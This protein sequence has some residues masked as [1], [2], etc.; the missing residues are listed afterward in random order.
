[1]AGKTAKTISKMATV[2]FLLVGAPIFAIVAALA[3][4][5]YF[6]RARSRTSRVILVLCL[7]IVT[8]LFAYVAITIN[9]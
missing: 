7:A 8:V 6:S 4:L 2:T 3:H 9:Q 5:P 1:M